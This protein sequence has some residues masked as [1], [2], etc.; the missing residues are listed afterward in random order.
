MQPGERATLEGDAE[1]TLR[2]G[3]AGAIA[4]TI[5]GR[6]PGAPGAGGAIRSVRVTPENAA[7]LK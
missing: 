3:D 5:N 6:D 2:F 7:T 4:W 1:V